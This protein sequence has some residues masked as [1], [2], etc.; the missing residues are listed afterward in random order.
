VCE[1]VIYVIASGTNAPQLISVAVGFGGFRA[2]GFDC[3]ESHPES[4]IVRSL[5]KCYISN[6]LDWSEDDIIWEDDGED[7]DDSDWVTDN[8]S[9]MS[10]D[11]ES[12]E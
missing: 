7:K 5:K 12:D 3:M 2:V 1:A 11:F 9:V 8:D 6:A 4:I 10:D